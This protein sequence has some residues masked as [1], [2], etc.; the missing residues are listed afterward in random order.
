MQH[1]YNIHKTIAVLPHI[2]THPS[3]YGAFLPSWHVAAGL[4]PIWFRGS[5]H[6]Y[7][8]GYGEW[9]MWH[10]AK[11]LTSGSLITPP[12]T[13]NQK[14]YKHNGTC[15]NKKSMVNISHVFFLRDFVTLIVISQKNILTQKPKLTGG[16]G[17]HHFAESSMKVR[18]LGMATVAEYLG[19]GR[20]IWPM[21]S[22]FGL[23]YRATRQSLDFRVS[24]FFSSELR[25]LPSKERANISWTKEKRGTNHRID[26]KAPTGRGDGTFPWRVGVIVKN[27]NIYLFDA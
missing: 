5:M 7:L 8:I 23:L 6:T 17:H 20:K 24:C 11:T 27:P 16:D 22:I 14:L 18:E 10:I 21:W 25:Y 1:T 26:S 2:K 15:M 3:F 13:N 9:D 19:S 12:T 4:G